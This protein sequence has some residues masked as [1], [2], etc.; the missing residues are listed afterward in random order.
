MIAI[1]STYAV[2]S[3]ISFY[4]R[5]GTFSSLTSIYYRDGKIFYLD[6]ILLP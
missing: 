3:S 2:N 6:I 1:E 5:D 4:Y